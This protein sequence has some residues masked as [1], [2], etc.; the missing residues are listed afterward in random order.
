MFWYAKKNI[1]VKDHNGTD[2][3]IL[4]TPDDTLIKSV[5]NLIQFADYFLF[6]SHK[7]S[8]ILSNI[9]VIVI[10]RLL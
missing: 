3:C 7:N 8:A 9:N 10:K 1:D 6:Y 5:L 4:V 2:P